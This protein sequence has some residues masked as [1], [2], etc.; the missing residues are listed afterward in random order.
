[1]TRA[2]RS[3]SGRTRSCSRVRPTTSSPARTTRRTTRR[4]SPPPRGHLF[5]ERLRGRPFWMLIACSLVNLTTWEQ[6]RPAF[7]HI[8]RTFPSIGALASARP[9][10]LASCL[11]PLGLWRTRAERLPRMAREWLRAGPPKT[12]LDVQRLPGCGKYA[13]D[14]FAVF[15]LDD[16][17]VEPTDGKLTWY[18]EEVRSGRKQHHPRAPSRN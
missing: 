15:V 5:Q 12:Y 8:R 17:S 14:S 3:V 9:S 11:R 16:L 7:L 10:Q 6:A 1:M 2:L 18:M 13:A 4:G